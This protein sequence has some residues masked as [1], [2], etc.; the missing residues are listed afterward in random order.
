M[1]VRRVVTGVDSSGKSIVISDG[2]S[3]RERVMEHTPGFVS[4]PLWR[5]EGPPDLTQGGA[6]DRIAAGGTM[7]LPEGG[8]SFWV[9]TFPPNSVMMSPDWNPAV[10][11]PEMAEGSPGIAERMEPNNPGMH[12][13]P[14]VDYV[15]VIKGP[16]TLELDDGKTVELQS[17]DTV[18]QQGARHA[19]RNRTEEPVT[20]SVV[21]LGAKT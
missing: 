21:L 2:A 9:I 15:T 13:T 14:T 12:R 18:V 5:S 11:G 19:W 16:V 1:Q 7:V 20:V 6:E 10:A 8:S 4:S 3:P 17:G